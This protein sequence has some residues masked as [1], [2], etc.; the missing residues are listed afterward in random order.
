MPNFLRWHDVLAWL[1]FLPMTPL[2][3]HLRQ[4]IPAE[5]FW[6]FLL[7]NAAAVVVSGVSCWTLGKVFHQRRLFDRWEVLQPAELAAVLGSI[8]LNALVSVAG[9]W[10]WT[11]DWILL[12]PS[13]F[14]STAL[15][16]VVMVLCM[17][18]GMYVFH[19]LAH[20]PWLFP[21]FHRFHHRHEATHP[22]SLFVLHPAEVLGF[23]GLMILFL[24]LYPMTG[25]GLVAFLTLNLAFG[26]LG[27]SGVEP[28]PR[29]FGRTPLLRQV[30]T[31]TF[32]AGHHEHPK[33]NFGFYTLLW[34]RLFGTL[35]PEYPQRF[36][37]SPAS[38]NRRGP[39]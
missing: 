13:G 6:F 12:R 4:L 30:G 35:H 34:D 22:L 38:S 27:H 25:A 1:Q 17:D 33:S 2:L 14:W 3:H 8:V 24:M 39:G 10:A 20:Q 5:A 23:G 19:R 32:H 37:G 9:W 16:C 18:L 15:D 11:L 36:T 7:V 28:F 29:R 26:T 31:S 21:L